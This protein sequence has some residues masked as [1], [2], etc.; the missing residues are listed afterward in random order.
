VVAEFAHLNPWHGSGELLD[1]ACVQDDREV[2]WIDLR[3][4]PDRLWRESLNS[5][6]RRCVRRAEQAGVRVRTATSR[7]E[8]LEF[9]RLHVLT[10]QRRQALGRYALAPDYFLALF[11]QMP[12]NTRLFLA[13]YHG[14]VV[15]GGLFLHGGTDV[16]WHLSAADL[17]FS[18]VRPVNACVFG[19]IQWASSEGKRRLLCGGGHAPDDGVFRFKASFSPLRARFRVYRRVHDAA[20]YAAL[21]RA[22]ALHH[23]A[24]GEGNGFFPAYRAA[25][26]A[27]TSLPPSEA[28]E[29]S[30]AAG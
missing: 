13:E 28:P 1:S 10:M 12:S 3:G 15:A 19:A 8:I 20:A 14:R 25:P 26:R 2:V 5:D 7:E 30:T 11:E 27:P 23:G 24:A 16:Y 4:G 22:W 17:E 18:R 21:T 6:A 29:R 9:H